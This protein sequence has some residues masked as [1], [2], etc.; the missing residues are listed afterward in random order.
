MK[1][2]VR[3]FRER[4]GEVVNG[5][6]PVEVTKNGRKVGTYIPERRSRDP[7]VARAAAESIARWQAE[8]RAKGIDLDAKFAAI[9]LSP[10]GEP[11]K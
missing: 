11:M 6:E 7:E 1:M 3:E 10:W 5:T 2:G 9:G 4:L 8:M